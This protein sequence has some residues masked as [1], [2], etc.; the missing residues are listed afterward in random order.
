VTRSIH[1]HGAI[2]LQRLLDISSRIQNIVDLDIHHGTAITVAVAYL[3]TG[4]DL[5]ALAMPSRGAPSIVSKNLIQGY[6]KATCEVADIVSAK[7][8]IRWAP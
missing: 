7:D 8:L 2:C 1:A 6:D 3:R 4:V 5:C